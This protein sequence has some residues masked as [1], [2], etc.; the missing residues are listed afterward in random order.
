MAGRVWETKR[1]VSKGRG[2][3]EGRGSSDGWAIWERK[4][5]GSA[6]GQSSGRTSI[7]PGRVDTG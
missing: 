1:M 6:P 5:P 3:L 2:Q 4:V 7:C